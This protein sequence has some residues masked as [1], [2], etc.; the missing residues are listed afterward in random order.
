MNKKSKQGVILINVGTPDTPS[1][2]DV[3][4]YLK[5]FL[6]DPYVLVMPTVLRWLL[7]YGVILPLRSRRS[8]AAYSK[9]WL[10][11]GSPLLLNSVSLVKAVQSV[12]GDGYDVR[13]GMRYGNPA[14]SS[15]LADMSVNC[16]SITAIP[17]FPQY[18]LATTKTAEQVVTAE[19]VKSSLT[20]IHWRDDFY[21]DKGYI[22]AY[23]HKIKQCLDQAPYDVLILSYHGLPYSHLTSLCD[24]VVRCKAQHAPC[25]VISNSNRQCY[26][27]Q[28]YATSRLIAQHLGLTDDDYRVSFQS[29]LGFNSWLQPYTDKI[30]DDLY[31]Q[32]K[33]RIVIATPA[34]VADCLETV[35]EI[36]I[37]LKEQW[38]AMGGVSLTV[39]PCLNDD[40]IWVD[41]LVRL[42]NQYEKDVV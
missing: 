41:A 25:P 37:E 19:L 17:L 9:V 40:P 29:R 39:V 36:A 1:V 33:R 15:V 24:Q 11:Q 5:E 30:L 26:R 42:I 31:N 18:A 12:L 7:L 21:N 23:S 28:C 4:R 14:L 8:S 16:D 22:A 2:R 27:A 34:F 20:Q 10:D 32:G 35:E 38:L 13:L 6:S 3:R